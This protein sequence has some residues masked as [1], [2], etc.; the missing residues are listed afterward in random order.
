MVNF[1]EAFDRFLALA[2]EREYS[3]EEC[4]AF[5]GLAKESLT[6][7]ARKLSTPPMIAH[8]L[9]DFW[10]ELAQRTDNRVA[11]INLKKIHKHIYQSVLAVM[12]NLRGE[13]TG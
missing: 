12:R 4:V 11:A 9:T 7:P 2:V 5:G 13:S 10:M 3:E 8:P 1:K 6:V